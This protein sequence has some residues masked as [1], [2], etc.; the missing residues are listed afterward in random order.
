MNYFSDRLNKL[1]LNKLIINLSTPIAN[2]TS[3][4]F[5]FVRKQLQKN[6]LKNE[7]RKQSSKRLQHE[8]YVLRF[9]LQAKK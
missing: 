2:C 1:L 8:I 6:R 4:P 5:T 9:V 3:A 7:N